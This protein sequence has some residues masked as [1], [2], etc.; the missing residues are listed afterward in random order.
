[1]RLDAALFARGLA[2]S[3]SHARQLLDSGAVRVDGV[4]QTRPSTAVDESASI[5]AAADPYVSRAAHK[6]RQA[7]AESGVVVPARVL[8]AG[9]STG[10]FSQV[11]LQAG[12]A[13]VF[14]VDVGHGQLAPQLRADPRLT[15]RE[16]V[17]VRDLSLDQL[18]GQPVE[19]VVADLSFISLTVVLA[20]LFS[21]LTADGRA[22]FL[23]KPQF[24]VGRAGLDD[25]GVVKTAEL[26]RRG[27][28]R[29]IARA[30]ELGWVLTWRGEAGLAGEKGNR[31]AF[32]LFDRRGVAAD[33]E[34]AT[35]GPASGTPS[36]LSDRLVTVEAMGTVPGVAR[37]MTRGSAR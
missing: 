33:I 22:L 20:A 34:A 30:A 25:H 35:V 17:N 7:L 21:V 18:D 32:C 23:V 13:R 29:V 5:E 11:L 26:R 27:V 1:M 2:R 28:D 8:D 36:S 12:A 10:G 6:L 14:A 19:L 16:G 37:G 9:A 24:E 31:E 4:V 3:R 15:V